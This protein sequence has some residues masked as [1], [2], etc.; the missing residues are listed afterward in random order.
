MYLLSSVGVKKYKEAYFSPEIYVNTKKFPK[1]F[2][3]GKKTSENKLHTHKK[4]KSSHVVIALWLNPWAMCVVIA[5]WLYPW[6][7]CGSFF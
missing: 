7:I 5:L 1:D 4:E 6:T 2:G 3:K